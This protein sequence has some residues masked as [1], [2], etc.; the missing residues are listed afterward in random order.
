MSQQRE[1]GEESEAEQVEDLCAQKPVG[2]A[3][4]LNPFRRGFERRLRRR[5]AESFNTDSFNVVSFGT[6]DFNVVSFS[7]SSFSAV[8]F[9]SDSF[10][11]VAC[12]AGDNKVVGFSAVVGLCARRCVASLR[13]VLFHRLAARPSAL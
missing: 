4:S 12:H 2:R 3:P 11:A 6:I 1:H 9:N 7:V 8:G 10:N 5:C 13:V